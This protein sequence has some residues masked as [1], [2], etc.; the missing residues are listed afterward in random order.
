MKQDP[1]LTRIQE[2]MK[3]GKL[4]ATGFLGEDRRPLSE[5]L[6]EDRLSVS[7]LGLSCHFIAHVLEKLMHKGREGFGNPVRVGV[8]LV[9]TVDENRGV[10]PCPF[11]HGYLAEKIDVTVKNVKSTELRFSDLSIHLIKE[12]CFFQGR[13]SVYRVDPQE[14]VNTLDSFIKDCLRDYKAL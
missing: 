12:H 1:E 7:N 13:G 8:D 2:L 9:V 11:R 6:E 10:V 5:I 14:L 3:P 4:S